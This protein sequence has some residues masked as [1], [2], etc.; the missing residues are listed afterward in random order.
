MPVSGTSLTYLLAYS[1][2]A[3]VVI[4]YTA[5]HFFQG[6]GASCN[7]GFVARGLSES[8]K[9]AAL[10]LHNKLRSKVALGQETRG[11]TGPQPPA[12]DMR[13]LAWD[14]EL[15]TIAQRWA[16][17]CSFGHDQ[18]R[19]VARFKVGQNVYESGSF[20]RRDEGAAGTIR[21]GLNSFFDEVKDFSSRGVDRYSFDSGTG[22]YTQMVWAKTD[23]LGC[24]YVSYK[25]GRFDKKYLVCNYGESGNFIGSS[26]YAKG[27]ACSRCPSGTAC[28]A[29]YP[30]LCSAGGGGGGG[31]GSAMVPVNRPVNP[32]PVN[33][34]PVNPVTTVI[35]PITS[36][37]TTRRPVNTGGFRPMTMTPLPPPTPTIT[38]PEDN[39]IDN[40]G[41]FDLGGGNS[42]GLGGNG[43]V[44]R[45]R[46]PSSTPPFRPSR[47]TTSGGNSGGFMSF[48]SPF[49]GMFSRRP[50]GGSSSSSFGFRG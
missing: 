49:F 38:F 29:T 19:N 42:N 8:E 48:F 26:M 14:D 16:E 24:G 7:G 40:T 46:P 3:P 35:R 13:Q 10:D 17:Q 50:S 27:K 1:R 12:A 20:G 37:P 47:P 39:S 34:V 9:A 25:S 36:R 18:V 22:H 31:G 5:R 2:I 11:T 15:A 6:I 41:N 28:S 4:S 33:P 21:A 23:R 45:P 43:V 32:V 44:F 30:G